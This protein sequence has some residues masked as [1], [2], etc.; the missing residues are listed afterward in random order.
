MNETATDESGI[1]PVKKLQIGCGGHPLNGWINTN[2]HED[3]QSGVL[4]L[5]ATQKF[6][7]QNNHFDYVFS[8]HMIEHIPYKEGM[9]MLAEIFRTLKPG[10]VVRITTPDLKFLVDMY[11]GELTGRREAYVRWATDSFVSDAD[12]Y[13]PIFVINNFFRSWGHLFIYDEETL[14]RALEMAGFRNIVR[15]GV[16]QSA[17]GALQGLEN[18]GRMPAGFLD[19]ESMCL[20]GVK[21]SV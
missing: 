4:P 15:F 2:L 3:R 9:H 21:P 11:Q 18:E 7:Y 1:N 5:D 19:Y 12:V 6:P 10:G 13:D 8:E 14:T 16:G 17:E 20:E